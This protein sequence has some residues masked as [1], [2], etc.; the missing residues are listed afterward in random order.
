M[1][2]VILDGK[3]VIHNDL[4]WD[5]VKT[6]F[7]EYE[8]YDR[9]PAEE[10]NAR[11]KDA[12]FIILNKIVITEDNLNAAPNLKYIG[13]LSTGYNTVDINATQKRG[14]TVCNIPDYSTNSVA[15]LVFGLLLHMTSKVSD[16]NN[17][18]HN[19]EWSNSKD[20]TITGIRITE[21]AGK[22]IGVMGFGNIGK[23]VSQI[24][25]AFEM[26]VLVYNRT[27]YSE[28]ENST[29]KFV[30]KEELFKQSDIISLHLPLNEET[31]HI[32]NHNSIKQMKNNVY[33]INTARGPEVDDQAILDAVNSKQIGGFACDV[34][35]VEPIP[36]DS[37]LLKSNDIVI[38]PHIAWS[39]IEART[40][41]I[42]I[43]ES[44]IKAF[45]NSHP[46]NVVNL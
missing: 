7:D 33:I 4:N 5:F 1:K 41:L 25:Q 38:T 19:G 27:T 28:F 31:T 39:T 22:T 29:L 15:Q 3:S 26:N 43:V 10:V 13:L 2:L 45:L 20:F 17:M 9:T 32:I 11:I 8:V 35:T 14:I 6:I 46:E 16:F 24:A 44:N 37:P 18:V 23:K 34:A 40:R 42:G 36:S 12:D 21:L 30:S